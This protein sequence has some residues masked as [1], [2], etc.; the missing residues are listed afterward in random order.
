MN[1]PKLAIIIPCYN[2]E[3]CVENTAQKLFA[4]LNTLLG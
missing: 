2:E 1:I 4:V 3:L